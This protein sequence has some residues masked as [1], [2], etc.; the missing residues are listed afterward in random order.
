MPGKHYIK[1]TAPGLA[2]AKSKTVE[3]KENSEAT[4]E[5][6]MEEACTIR[7]CVYRASDKSSVKEFYL[8]LNSVQRGY[9][10]A[11]SRKKFLYEDGSFICSGVEPG[12]YSITITAEG[13]P[14]FKTEPFEVKADAENKRDIYISEGGTVRGRVVNESEHGVPGAVVEVRKPQVYGVKTLEQK[15][16]T[17]EIGAFVLRNLT[18]GKIRLKVTHPDYATLHPE[19]I[20]VKKDEVT[21][22]VVLQLERGTLVYGWFKDA[23]GNRK[24][25]VL[26][27]VI[28]S[29]AGYDAQVRTDYRGEY[30]FAHVPKGICHLSLGYWESVLPFFEIKDEEEKE[31]NI[32]FSSAGKISGKVYLFSPPEGTRVMLDIY[33]HDER[34][35]WR[36]RAKVDVAVRDDGTFEIEG[37][38]PGKYEIELRGYRELDSGVTSQLTFTTSPKKLEVNISPREELIKDIT[39]IEITEPSKKE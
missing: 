39:V 29:D 21:D 19:E 16:T 7:G 38:L 2:E 36:V 33:G 8:T 35:H 12:K 5:I 26:I 34:V 4:V 23:D 31:I 9:A 13:L 17:D 1:V 25:N 20:T 22:K 11:Y 10:A 24:G 27:R 28:N 6:Y 37:L 30:R 32:D 18:P 15:I 14:R 3:V